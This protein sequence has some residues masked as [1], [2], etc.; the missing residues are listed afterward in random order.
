MTNTM[1]GKKPLLVAFILWLGAM[2]TVSARAHYLLLIPSQDAVAN[3]REITLDVMSGHPMQNEF[4]DTDKPKVFG[5]SIKGLPPIDLLDTLKEKKLDG[6]TIWTISYKIKQPG[7]HVFFVEQPPF[8]SS[9]REVFISWNAKVVVNGLDREDGWDADLGLRLEIEPLVRPYGLWTGNLFRGIVKLDGK[10]LPNT[11][12]WVTY[13]SGPDGK[14]L[15][16]AANSHGQTIKTNHS[17]EFSYAMPRAGWWGFCVR[18]ETD[19]TIKGEDGKEHPVWLI[20]STW[21]HTSDME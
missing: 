5:V 20:S 13:Y 16:S 17:G 21:V 19:E 3:P 4:I 12:V 11:K 18:S 14:P 8:Y 9:H 15:T 1:L 7:D 2:A 10:P 6:S